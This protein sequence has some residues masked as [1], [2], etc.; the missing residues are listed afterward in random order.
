MKRR[1]CINFGIFVIGFFSMMGLALA[2][3]PNT[4]PVNAPFAGATISDWKGKIHLNLPG[5][6]QSAPVIG[7]TLPPGTVLE[8]GGG[9]LLLQL[10]D[11]SQVLI[12]AHTRLTVQ[13]PS[14]TDRGYFQLLLGRIRAIIT[15]RTGGAAPFELGTPSAVIA[16]RGTE[17]EVELNRRQETEVD[18]IEG[19]VEVIGRH[20]RKSVF[21]QAGSS[22][23]VGMDTEPEEPR[24]TAEMHSQAEKRANQGSAAASR[25]SQIARPRG[26][27]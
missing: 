23:R 21:V 6:T 18:V 19:V 9:R 20:S 24:S 14:P 27:P 26:K 5:E 17:F 22:T 11:G 3:E 8:T 4:V 7:E 13:Q 10:T 2:Q 16:V 15:K 25:A 1:A 12:R